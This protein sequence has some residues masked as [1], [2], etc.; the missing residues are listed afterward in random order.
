[1]TQVF[2]TAN[3]DLAAGMTSILTISPEHLFELGLGPVFV[4]V[5]EHFQALAL[6]VFTVFSC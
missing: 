3:L 4:S 1:M 5:L 2:L 6:W